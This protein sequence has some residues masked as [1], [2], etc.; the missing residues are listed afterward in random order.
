MHGESLEHEKEET[1]LTHGNLQIICIVVLVSAIYI[2]DL[3]SCNFNYT[4]YYPLEHT[5]G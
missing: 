4:L 3:C 2:L 5:G 1:N